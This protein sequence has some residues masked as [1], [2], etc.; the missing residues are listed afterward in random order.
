MRLRFGRPYFGSYRDRFDIAEAKHDSGLI[1][2]P[3]A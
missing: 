3:E 1:R 2:G